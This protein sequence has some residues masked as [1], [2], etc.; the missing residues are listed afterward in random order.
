MTKTLGLLGIP[1][2]KITQFENLAQ[3]DFKSKKGTKNKLL[4]NNSQIVKITLIIYIILGIQFQ[5]K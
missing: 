1:V 2:T 5:Y 3:N 4:S